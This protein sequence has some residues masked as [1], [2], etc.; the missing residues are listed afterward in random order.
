MNL[1]NLNYSKENIKLSKTAIVWESEKS[2]LKY[3][4]Y[5]GMDNDI[6]VACCGSNISAYQVQLLL[7]AGAK[8]M[9]I[10]FD[11]QWQEKND[12]EYKHYIKNLEKLNERFKNDI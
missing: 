5:F 12:D 10:A 8:E 2:C 1:Y 3:Q 6:S 9:V 7:D 11:R 4:S